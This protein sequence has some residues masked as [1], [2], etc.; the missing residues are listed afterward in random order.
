MTGRSHIDSPSFSKT[1]E[2]RAEP[3]Y[4]VIGKITF[5]NLKVIWLCSQF[6]TKPSSTA[7]VL[8][9]L[10]KSQAWLKVKERFLIFQWKTGEFQSTQYIIYSLL[11]MLAMHCISTRALQSNTNTNAVIGCLQN[12][13]VLYS[14]CSV[15]VKV[16]LLQQ[17]RNH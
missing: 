16:V 10:L 12:L 3:Y 8:H 7:L 1:R 13:L 17:N 5:P 11:C 2:L 6:S 9:Q 15:L 4:I 14:Y